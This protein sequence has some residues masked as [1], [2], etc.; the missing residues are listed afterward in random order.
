M[1]WHELDERMAAGA[2]LVDVR[3]P[4][5]FA[6]GGIP[7]SVNIPLDELRERHTEIAGH[8]DVIVHCQVG[9]RGHNAACLLTNLGYSVANLDG[10]YLTWKHGK[11]SA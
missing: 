2:L 4:G 9:L 7:G 5:E 11:A 8:E 3:S 10:G 6:S 1:Q